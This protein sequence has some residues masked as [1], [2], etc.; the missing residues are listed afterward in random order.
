MNETSGAAVTVPANVA[1]EG[2][3]AQLVYILYLVGIII[4]IASIVGVIMAYVNKGTAPAWVQDHY[5]YQIRT[6]WI[7]LLFGVIGAATAV[8]VIG[9]F[10]LLFTVVWLIIRSVQ[11]MK[12]LNEGRPPKNVTSWFF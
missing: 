11:G 10:I 6:F 4:G 1:A 5:R 3:S 9:W 7:E 12:A 8:F 2:K